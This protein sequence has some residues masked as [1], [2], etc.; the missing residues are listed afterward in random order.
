MRKTTKA[1]TKPASM[2]TKGKS[3]A[4]R[5]TKAATRA[6]PKRVAKPK[7]SAAPKRKRSLIQK[8]MH[9]FG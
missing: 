1:K 7:K 9:P 4:K 5:T 6:M 8:I 3:P 2:K